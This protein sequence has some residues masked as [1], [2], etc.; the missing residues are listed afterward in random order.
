MY[1]VMI[2]E[3]EKIIRT[4]IVSIINRF[5]NGLSVSGEYS[6]AFDAWEVFKV[7][8]PDIII[9]DIVMK[10]MSGLDLLQK[11]RGSGSVVPVIILSGYSDFY[12]AQTAIRYNVTEY[13]LKPV[14][15]KQ[16][17]SVLSKIKEQLDK[18]GASAPNKDNEA[19]DEVTGKK[20]ICRTLE[21]IKENLDGDLSLS[22]VAAKVGLSTNYLSMLFRTETNEKYSD[23][24]TKL[25]IEKACHLLESSD[26]K[27]YEIAELCGYN[28]VNH[29]I[30][31][32]KKVTGFTPSSYKNR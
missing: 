12:Y 32:F 10:G 15:V 30:G 9:T 27:I 17:I 25:R 21:Y 8:P 13:A 4:G 31:V 18:R 22:T 26:F 6:N 5:G 14:N 20:S 2:V 19:L 16:F 11:I 24:V 1:R 23:Y 29:F 3:D 7:D 28:S